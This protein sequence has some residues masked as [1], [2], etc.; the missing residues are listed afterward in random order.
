MWQGGGVSWACGEFDTEG[1]SG[2]ALSY[3]LE[4]VLGAFME[5]SCKSTL[6]CGIT[7]EVP[8]KVRVSEDGN[9]EI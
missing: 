9:V 2:E 3:G 7:G 6:T 4:G 1:V 8:A 5:E